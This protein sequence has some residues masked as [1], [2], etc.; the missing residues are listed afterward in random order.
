MPPVDLARL[1]VGAAFLA[2]VAML[3]WRTRKVPDKA[4]IALGAIAMVLTLLDMWSRNEDPAVGLVLV[5]IAL[6]LFDPLIGPE[7]VTEEGAWQIRPAPLAAYVGAY[8]VA[9]GATAY[10]W[11]DLQG[12]PA[13]PTFVAY[14]AVPVMMLLFR[15]MFYLHLMGGADAKGLIVIAALVPL[16]P[17]L[18]PFPL[19]SLDPRLQAAAAVFP[20]SFVVLANGYLLSLIVVVGMLL[21]NL[22][23]RHLKFPHSLIGVK[24][25]LDRVPMHVWFMDMIRDGKHVTVFYPREKQDRAAIVRDLKAAG[26]TEAWVTPGIPLLVFL[27]L[28]YVA[29][30]LAGNLLVWLLSLPFALP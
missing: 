25:P 14:L 12:E 21:G 7:F 26:F 28:G 20:F 1:A 9:I 2:Y 10:A 29:A 27:F 23:H 16:S 13:L 15:G 8:V 17:V 5:P 4:W 3:D 18:P 11:M 22:R 19:L 24:V 30:F 6:L